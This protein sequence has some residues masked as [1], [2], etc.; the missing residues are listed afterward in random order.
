MGS[1][2]RRYLQ[3]VTAESGL[4]GGQIAYLPHLMQNS[5]FRCNLGV[6]NFG[7]TPASV[8]VTLYDGAGNQLNTFGLSIP[9]GQVKQDNEPFWVRAGRSDLDEAYASVNV[10]SGTGV[11]VYAS[12]IDQGTGDATTIPMRLQDE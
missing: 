1:A 4:A 8:T 5:G 11:V 6:A 9:A 3:G 2:S 7:P 10:N 12:V